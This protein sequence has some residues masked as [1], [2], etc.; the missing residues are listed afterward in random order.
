MLMNLKRVREIRTEKFPVSGPVA[1]W[2]SRDQRAEDN[3]ALLHAQQQALALGQPLLVVFCLT[4]AF[5]TATQRQYGF[6]LRGLAEAFA[7]LERKNI[8]CTLLLG[9][10]HEILP[11][12][13][14]QQ[15]AGLLV[16]DFDPLKIKRYWQKELL[17][18]TDLTVH[19]VDAHNIVP[20][21]QASS[22]LEFAAYT[23]RPK[24]KKLLPEYLEEYPK[25]VVHPFSIATATSPLPNVDE[26]LEKLQIDRRVAEVTWLQ[27]GGQAAQI[28]LNSFLQHRL[29]RYDTQSN[30][31][32]R[33]LQSNLSPY[34]HFG[35]LSAQR[36][37]LEVL[38]QDVKTPAAESFLEELIVRR[39]LADNFCYYNPL[40]DSVAGF[41][42][43]AQKT[44]AEHVDDEREYRYTQDELEQARTHE[45]IWNAAQQ[46]LLVTGKM[47]GYMRMYW[48]KKILEWSASPRQAMEIA[49]YLNDKY[50]LDGR[51]PNGYTGI[52]WS[53]G[54]VHD[55]A[56]SE[57]P[58][59]G[60]I[61]FMN[62]KGIKRKFA[63]ERYVEKMNSWTD[64][65]N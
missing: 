51:D 4:P 5:L 14:N 52:A 29:C 15:Q 1:Y 55:R 7:E 36:V 24:I 32:T 53:I 21:W 22:K 44:L 50:E 13:L 40:Y 31:P 23:L 2:M 34:L 65:A 58:V 27:P 30:D 48:A 39:E 10:P 46:Q 35:Q 60:K 49:I 38:R 43:W 42:A 9:Q 25:L 62:D 20:C 17:A 63:I 26:L 37:A 45:P 57:R 59:F 6:M 11:A 64:G 54:G 16:C 61:R 41:P 33:D 19:E 47:H 8:A 12:W 3:W 18:A 28:Q 56:W